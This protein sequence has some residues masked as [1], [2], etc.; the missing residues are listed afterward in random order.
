M[1]RIDISSYPIE[2]VDGQSTEDRLKSFL[3][4]AQVAVMKRLA[5]EKLH[6][7]PADF[8]KLAMGDLT[9]EYN[10]R[11]SMIEVMFHPGLQ[12]GP[13]DILDRDHLAIKIKDWP[14]NSLLLE[15][16]E[17]KKVVA[18]L[19]IVRGL[20]RESVEFV[21]RILNAPEIEVQPKKPIPKPKAK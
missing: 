7:K 8:D 11:N 16:E 6:M 4:S 2:S 12:L 13:R 3:A 14:D 9:P 17:Y 19:E 18:G 10:V 5:T 15:E 1:R 20:G 21:K